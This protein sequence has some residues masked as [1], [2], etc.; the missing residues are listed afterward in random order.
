[1]TCRSFFLPML[2]CYLNL[3]IEA[4]TCV[5]RLVCHR[6]RNILPFTGSQ[7]SLYASQCAWIL[8]EQTN[9]VVDAQHVIDTRGAL[10]FLGLEKNGLVGSAPYLAGYEAFANY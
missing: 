3:K 1:M 7:E 4:L 8:A 2:A 10:E 5:E 6:R 9:S